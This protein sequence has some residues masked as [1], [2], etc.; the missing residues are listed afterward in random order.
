MPGVGF[1]HFIL[2]CC[3]YGEAC[4]PEWTDVCVLRTNSKYES[5]FIFNC[6]KMTQLYHSETIT[7]K[8]TK[9]EENMNE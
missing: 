8:K 6:I 3:K 1:D 4:L 2:V 5:I 9:V 7:L